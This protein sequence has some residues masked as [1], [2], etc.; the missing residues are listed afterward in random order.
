MACLAFW[1]FS[2]PEAQAQAFLPSSIKLADML[3]FYTPYLP[4]LLK[5]YAQI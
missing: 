5:M 2:I 4:K 1:G 3:R